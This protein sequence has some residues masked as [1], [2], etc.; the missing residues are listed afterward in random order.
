MK[1]LAELQHKIQT[2]VLEKALA[3]ELIASPP[4]GTRDER[5]S[6][7]RNAYGLRLTEFLAHDY[8]KLR[9]YLGDVRFRDMAQRYIE[10][11]PSD[12]PNARWFSRHLPEFLGTSQHYEHQPEIAELARLERALNDAFDGPDE[13]VCTMA[14][15]AAVEPEQFGN[16]SFLIASTVH[17]FGVT[18]N[19]SSLWSCLKC[20]EIPPHPE[21]ILKPLEIMVWRQASGARFRILGDEEAMAVDSARQGLSFGIICEMMAA[22]DDPDNAAIR[23]AGYLRG[24]IEAEI[25][26]SLRVE[27]GI[28]K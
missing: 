1:K 5:L 16:V 13:P 2:A 7:Y 11:Y 23:A 20:D 25:I 26:S 27:D 8:G 22:F 19:V 4:E 24:W 17:R 15:L 3:D 18:T 14:D 9:T 12:Q 10:A 21:G 28:E 6:V